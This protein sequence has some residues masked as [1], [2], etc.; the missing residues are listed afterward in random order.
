ME[1]EIAL[2]CWEFAVVYALSFKSSTTSG[3]YKRLKK[4][5]H[6]QTYSLV[7]ALA[8]SGGFFLALRRGVASFSNASGFF[9]HKGHL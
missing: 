6:T 1:G 9:S 7:R 2:E 4:I 5:I 8:I 3:N